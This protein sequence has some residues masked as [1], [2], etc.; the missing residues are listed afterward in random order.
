MSKKE[1]SVHD[2]SV[3]LAKLVVAYVDTKELTIGVYC[4]IEDMLKANK[5]RA[6]RKL[7]TLYKYKIQMVIK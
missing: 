4:T 5:N 6:V 2:K 7:T 3:E 1:I